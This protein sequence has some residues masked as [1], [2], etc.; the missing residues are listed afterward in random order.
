MNN[1]FLYSLIDFKNAP[2]C[3]WSVGSV[4]I[5][6]FCKNDKIFGMSTSNINWVRIIKMILGM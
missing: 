4:R 2:E 1:E 5:S 3:G 6:F